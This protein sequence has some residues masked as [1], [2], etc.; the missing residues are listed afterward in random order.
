MRSPLPLLFV[1]LAASCQCANPSPGATVLSRGGYSV[2]LSTDARSFVLQ[3]EGT[4]L[5]RFE[6]D[7]F[8]L[9][10]V[11][12]LD[13]TLSYDP[14]W[15][16]QG[17]GPIPPSPPPGLEW[18]RAESATL[19]EHSAE[20]LR[21]RLQFPAGRATLTLR[22][23]ADGRFAASLA[24]AVDDGEIAFI[25]LRPRGSAT[26]AFYGLG[27]WPDEVNHRGKRRQMQLEAD[28]DIESGYTENH[29]SVP[30]LIGTTGWGIFVE[31]RR[32]GLFDVATREDD[33]V[34]ITF[35]T[36]EESGEGLL[37]HLFAAPHPLDVTRHYYEVTGYPLLPAPWALGPWIWRDENRDQA[38]VHDDIRKI[39]ELDLATSAI[40]ID[41][42][43][44]TRVNT[45]DFKASD[46]PDPAAMI[47]DAHAS[48]LRMA[49]WHTPYL[50][51]P[52]EG[53]GFQGAE[54]YLSEAKAKG[55][56]P[57]KAGLQLNKWSDPIDLTNPEAY[58]WWQSLIRKYT[59][60][61]IE[62]FKLDY[63]EDVV[64]GLA[65]ARSNWL[66]HDGSDERT[67]QHEY[68]LLYHRVYAE[69]LPAEGGFLLC[70]AGRWGSQKYASVIWPG[71]LDATLT[72]HG[73]EFTNRAGKKIV[74]VGGLPAAV[75]MSLNLGP[76]GFPFF[77]SDTGG[78]RQS[79]P[80]KETFVRWA[81][82]TALS[83]VMQVGDSSSQTPW[84]FNA[85]NG[86]DQ[87]ALDIYREYARLH[88]RLFPYEWTYAKRIALDGR[89]IQRA[90]G[91]AYP[92]L[93]VHPPDTYLFGEAL[94]VAPVITQGQREREAPLP[95]GTWIDWWDGTEYAG[96][97]GR[98]ATLP[99][100][101]D[102]L[103]LLIRAGG[104]VPMLRPTIDT[105]SPTTRPEEIDSFATTPGVLWTRFAR[106]S[107][108]DLPSAL[109][110]AKKPF[111]FVLYDGTKL[112]QLGNDFASIL[113][114]EPGTAG[115]EGHVFELIRTPQPTQVSDAAGDLPQLGSRDAVA[116]SSRGWFWEPAT[117]G[118]VWLRTGAEANRLTIKY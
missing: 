101:L 72:K 43:Y 16:E 24:P 31:S 60:L 28:L 74:G 32:Y 116:A 70:R 94:L 66:F 51:V 75:A 15:L 104:I 7:A 118:T 85:Q 93:G 105:L 4:T 25:R 109:S 77:G 9:G 84:E 45:F 29:V 21:V 100:P 18:V 19:E 12:V 1:L 48:G 95:P 88:L 76:S 52:K 117:G 58:A 38:Q 53:N 49:L 83:T 37:F 90:I 35:G 63:A 36:A 107:V 111:E 30:L 56:F 102:R 80:D 98:T 2:E 64:A 103:P 40:W 20:S 46:F 115:W 69:T 112:S 8:E 39:R 81:Q 79:P 26:E 108:D 47:A 68:T 11:D 78:Y 57:P 34:E 5:L 65:G 10:V 42:P 23:V 62:G 91:L 71:D 97:P 99:A 27:E 87:E 59:D 73:E 54:P 55:Y 113:E 41:R 114:V 89:P 92:E 86:R 110:I 13:D 44:A 67:M 82:Q 3:R 6:A 50:E 14:F 22:A 17:T 33:L 106:D 61:G 96:G